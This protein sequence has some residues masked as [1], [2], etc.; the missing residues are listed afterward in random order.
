MALTIIQRRICRLIAENRIA[1]GESYVAGGVALNELISAP[2]ISRDIGLFHDTDEALEA[3]WAADRV[4][5]EKNGFEIRVVRERSSFV[6]AEVSRDGDTVVVQWARDSAFRFFPLLPHE[7]LGLT[8]HPFD[9]AT[10]KVL[11]LVGRLEVRDWIDVINCDERIQPLGYL[12]W[13]AS[14]KDPGFSPEAIL[15]HAGRTGRYSAEEVRELAFESEPPDA[16]ELSRKWHAILDAA[17]QVIA[18]LP[19][20]QAGSCVITR[21]GELY[22][23]DVSELRDAM[24]RSDIRFHTGRIRG[25]FPVVVES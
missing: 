3:T 16:K 18:A 13:A 7:E 15:E 22:C 2:R 25:A 11:A 19:A 10:N 23:G 9:V 5:M 21:A 6:E 12:A 20:D 14:G 4:L 24:N 8:L 1:S 17:R